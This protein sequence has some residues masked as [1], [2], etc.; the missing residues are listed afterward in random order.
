MESR[1]SNDSTVG[2]LNRHVWRMSFPTMAGMLLQAVYDLVDM[3][4]IGFI[5]PEAVAAVT[6]FITLFWIVEIL[7]EIVGTSS[8]S[9]ISQSYG[10]GDL[11]RTRIISEQTLVFKALLA[12]LGAIIMLV[13][14]K[15]LLHFF[16][17]D[18]KVIAHGIEYG[19]IRLIF[20]P[21]FFSSYSVNTIFRCTGDAKTPMKL[22]ITSAIIN[23]VADPLLM[24][25]TIPGTSIKGLGWGMQG[26][27]IATV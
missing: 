13:C 21:I 9:M 11:E 17:D 20:L 3:I 22:L 1:V 12:I 2:D 14:L 4:W 25:D 19:V 26:A 18:S 23:M 24:F 6:I 5:S 15:P 10:T 8:V 27:A 7:N 16:T